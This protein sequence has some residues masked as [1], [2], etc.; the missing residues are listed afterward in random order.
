MISSS[1]QSSVRCTPFLCATTFYSTSPSEPTTVVENVTINEVQEIQPTQPLE[2][3]ESVDPS[4]VMT[5]A[6]AYDQLPWFQVGTKFLYQMHEI[7]GL[8]WWASILTSAIIV[9]TIT[10]PSNFFIV[11]NQAKSIL[12]SPKLA[13]VRTRYSKMLQSPYTSEQEKRN[14]RNELRSKTHEV[15]KQNGASIFGG[16]IPVFFQLPFL[17]YLFYSIRTMCMND[18]WGI[19]QEGLFWASSLTMTDPLM[20]TPILSSFTFLTAFE[21]PRL[22]SRMYGLKFSRIQ[23]I[24]APIIRTLMLGVMFFTMKLPIAVHM[25]FLGTGFVNVLTA[26]S[27]RSR[28]VRQVLGLPGIAGLAFSMEHSDPE[29][30]RRLIDDSNSPSR[31]GAANK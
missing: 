11:R 12:C 30:V 6:E 22:F 18:V 8:P 16:L 21:I 25:Y 20:I 4:H 24:A 14:L 28:T 17:V 5:A 15:M 9:R 10:L 7:T 13:A 3:S 26:L 2:F 1:T 23:Q 19:S 27:W 29:I 31:G